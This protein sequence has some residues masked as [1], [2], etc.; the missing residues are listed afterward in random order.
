MPK[1]S[2]FLVS[3]LF[4]QNDEAKRTKWM[5]GI[6]RTFS[7]SGINAC[8]EFFALGVRVWHT[9]FH[10]C[11]RR[12]PC[13]RYCCWFWITK[14]K[15]QFVSSGYFV[16]IIWYAQWKIT[17]KTN[18]GNKR[19]FSSN[20]ILPFKQFIRLIMFAPVNVVYVKIFD[21]G[22]IFVPPICSLRK[23][24]VELCGKNK[25]KMKMKNHLA[26]LLHQIHF[27]LHFHLIYWLWLNKFITR[28]K[29][30]KK[31][32]QSQRMNM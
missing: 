3:S 12:R 10:I 23:L 2:D 28:L 32:A 16:R 5:R 26:L 7:W 22:S 8:G 27:K 13:R 11:R 15:Y 14:R 31:N 29:K 20:G 6:L 24:K 19:L 21:F 30:K 25:I 4:C 1:R 9:V 17:H 18:E